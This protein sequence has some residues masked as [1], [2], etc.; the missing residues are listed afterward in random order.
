MNADSVMYREFLAIF[1][2][3]ICRIK[4]CKTVNVFKFVSL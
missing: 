2:L 4:L 1:L 3:V